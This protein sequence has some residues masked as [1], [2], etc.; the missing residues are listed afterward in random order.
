LDLGFVFEDEDEENDKPCEPDF[1]DL[2]FDAVSFES[3][4]F[5]TAPSS[6][7]GARPFS[8]GDQANGK[9][10]LEYK[11]KKKN[12]DPTKLT[13]SPYV[14]RL[15]LRKMFSSLQHHN[16]RPLID[17]VLFLVRTPRVVLGA[18]GDGRALGDRRSPAAYVFELFVLAFI[19]VVVWDAV[20]AILEFLEEG[21]DILLV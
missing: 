5:S 15:S 6:G 8:V 1:V 11:S 14:L 12:Q 18:F 20:D 7:R 3:G 10:L 13:L 4:A 16:L 9:V 19:F 2:V 17:E 21:W